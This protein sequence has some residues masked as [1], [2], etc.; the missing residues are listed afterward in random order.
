MAELGQNPKPPR[1][2]ACVFIPG[3]CEERTHEKPSSGLDGRAEAI[4]A[5]GGLRQ[6]LAQGG[7]PWGP[8][9]ALPEGSRRCPG[10]A[11]G[12]A[13]SRVRALGL[14]R[15]RALQSAGRRSER[16]AKLA[17]ARS[18]LT[19]NSR[20]PKERLKFYTNPLSLRRKTKCF[21]SPKIV[22]YNKK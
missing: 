18:R 20:G 17:R 13:R 10:R 22:V 16:W 2:S 12:R 1:S 6:L 7:S 9:R 11:W 8:S 4:A 15:T 14:S 5:A 3:G 19:D 21:F